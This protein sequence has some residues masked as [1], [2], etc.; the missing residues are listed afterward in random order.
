MEGHTHDAKSSYGNCTSR[1][2]ALPKT[3]QDTHPDVVCDFEDEQAVRVSV[4]CAEPGLQRAQGGPSDQTLSATRCS[5]QRHTAAWRVL[6]RYQAAKG[7][8]ADVQARTCSGAARYSSS[9]ML[10]K[11]CQSSTYTMATTTRLS[12][13]RANRLHS[14]VLF[15]GEWHW[16]GDGLCEH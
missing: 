12:W 4:F 11:S 13:R 16:A 9:A 8:A 3:A 6:Q 5:A 1:R 2:Q 15:A 7:S 10:T 14:H